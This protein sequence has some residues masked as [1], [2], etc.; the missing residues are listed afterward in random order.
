[1]ALESEEARLGCSTRVVIPWR[2]DYYRVG[3]SETSSSQSRQVYL[4]LDAVWQDAAT[5]RS[6]ASF[7][8]SSESLVPLVPLRGFC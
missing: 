3:L 1:M 8:G 5:A 6:L 2:A 7:R 4:T